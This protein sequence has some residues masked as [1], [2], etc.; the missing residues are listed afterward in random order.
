MPTLGNLLARAG[1]VAMTPRRVKLTLAVPDPNGGAPLVTAPPLPAQVEVALLPVSEARKAKAVRAAQA[2]VESRLPFGDA[3]AL[4]DELVFQFLVA[5][6]RD[7]EDLRK[8]FADAATVD[9]L[10]DSIVGEQQT[11]LA[12]EY[13]ALIL[14]EYGEVADA[15]IEKMKQEATTF[16]PVGQ[17]SP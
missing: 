3:P 4:G 12:A 7:P 11:Y 17:G 10:R 6:M 15:D 8:P 5:A 9:T 1:L 16:F 2:Y 13:K 14:S